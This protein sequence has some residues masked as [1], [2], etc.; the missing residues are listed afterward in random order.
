MNDKKTMEL[1]IREEF[2]RL[3]QPLT[4][5]NRIKLRDEVFC[6]YTKREI[7]IWGDYH[8]N[9][10]ER[11]EACNKVMV[12]PNIIEMEFDNWLEAAIYICRAEF[13]RKDLAYEYR[14][15]L[16]GKYFDYAKKC[17]RTDKTGDGNVSVAS[18][19]AKELF[20][21]AGTVVKYN[22]FS[23]AIDV[24]Y[25]ESREL[26][27]NI[28]L[29][30]IRISHDNVVELSRLKPEEIKAV[31]K[32][33]ADDEVD[34]ITFSYI[35]NEV[36]WSH[37]QQRAPSSRRERQE[38]RRFSKPAIRQMPEYDPDAEVNSLCMTID[39]W[40]SSIQRVN[41]SD[42]LSKISNKASLK[43]MKKLTY[44]EG[45]IGSIQNNLVERTGV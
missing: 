42:N 24:I 11:L 10:R 45:T 32:S 41:N 25:D 7:H 19:L 23:S 8:L 4:D 15:Y 14:K 18:T 12:A 35:R 5:H 1:T 6:D 16:I 2:E 39:S 29:G 13:Q 37:V 17:R 44:L 40:V 38:E 3:V 22:V 33:A 9:D 30:K 36:K 34:R 20:I 31:A 26:A 43:L 21:S 27:Q 28:L